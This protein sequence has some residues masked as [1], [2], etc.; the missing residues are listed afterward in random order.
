V[1]PERALSNRK[2]EKINDIIHDKVGIQIAPFLPKVLGNK[3]LKIDPIK[4]RNTAVVS[5]FN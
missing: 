5:I 2:I 3:P 1:S 4:G